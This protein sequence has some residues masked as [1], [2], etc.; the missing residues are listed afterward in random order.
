MHKGRLERCCSVMILQAH[1]TPSHSAEFEQA[2][3]DLR[4]PVI[5]ILDLLCVHKANTHV[6]PGIS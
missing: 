1:V 5:R 3:A 6:P 4:A 2:Q